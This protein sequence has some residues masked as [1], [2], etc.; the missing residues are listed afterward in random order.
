MGIGPLTLIMPES[1]TVK[2]ALTLVLTEENVS[3]ESIPICVIVLE[4]V[5]WDRTAPLKIILILTA[6]MAITKEL[7]T[8]A[9]L[10]RLVFSP[11]HLTIDAFRVKRELPLLL[12]LLPLLKAANHALLAHMHLPLV[13]PVAFLALV[14][15]VHLLVFLT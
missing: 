1:K 14:L 10:A 15:D 8:V 2:T 3:T 11:C 6:P 9:L 4:L 13:Y 5:I 7:I 12:M